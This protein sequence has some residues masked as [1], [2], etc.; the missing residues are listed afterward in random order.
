MQLKNVIS[1]GTLLCCRR[2][3]RTWESYTIRGSC[4]TFIEP[5]NL[6]L[7]THVYFDDSIDFV[8]LRFL[9]D[10][11][12]CYYTTRFDVFEFNWIVCS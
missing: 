11:K 3:L 6:A 1:V 5:N 10:E 7:V 2:P 12:V 4:G 8:A 9:Y